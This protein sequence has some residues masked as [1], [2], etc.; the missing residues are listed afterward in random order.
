MIK[1]TGLGPVPWML[2]AALMVLTAAGAVAQWH[3]KDATIGWYALAQMPFYGL[4]AWV[5][6]MLLPQLVAA[7]GAAVYFWRRRHQ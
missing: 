5:A 3:F 4:A 2:A 1:L 6:I 7:A